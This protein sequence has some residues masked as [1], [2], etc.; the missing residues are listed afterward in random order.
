MRKLLVILALVLA[1]TSCNIDEVFEADGG[2]P[3]IELD[4]PT[5]VYKTKVGYA[6]TISPTYR[7]AD[8][9]TT[10]TWTCEGVRVATTPTYS[11]TPAS[12][13][14]QFLQIEVRNQ[15]GSAKREIRVDVVERDVAKISL[16]GADEGFV[17]AIGELLPLRPHVEEC[18]LP[19]SYSWSLDGEV[20]GTERDYDFVGTQAGQHHMVLCATTDDGAA[21]L[22]FD[23]TVCRAED[24][25]LEWCFEQTEFNMASGRTVLLRPLDIRGGEG[26]TYEWAVDGTLV[27]TG[28]DASYAFTSS[29][30]GQHELCITARRD[31]ASRTQR[32][33]VNVCAA[34]G[35]FFRAA[36]A[37]SSAAWTKIYEVCAA[38]GQYINEDFEATT[39]DEACRKADELMRRG[40]CVSLGSFGGYIVV[41]FDHSVVTTGGYDLAIQGNPFDTSSEPAIVYVMQ[42]ENGDGV[43]NDTWYELAGSETGKAETLRDYAVTYYRP[44]ASCMSVEWRDNRGNSGRVEYIASHHDQPS[45]YPQWNDRAS[46]TLR[47]TRLAARNYDMT[48]NG[49]QWMLP[50]YDWGYADNFSTIDG[51]TD[52][53]VNRFRITDA[54]DHNGESIT[55]A[56]IDFVKIQTACNANSGWLGEQSSEVCAI[57]DCALLD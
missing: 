21:S 27:Q 41:G 6:L 53:G 18:A 16:A 43:P 12:T 47:G 14:R 37:S 2:V 34:E 20:V 46:Y 24:M 44:T 49:A 9:T 29:D 38:P 55:L 31:N 22:E 8:E 42:D 57:Y 32:L 56:Y 1:A 51:A 4:S 39:A 10:Y 19:I 28:A 13:G 3:S 15:Y 23:I 26:A 36:T 48:G 54:I 11:F 35:E 40:S 7:N 30:I 17:A 45:Y 50:P 33:T 52:G 25:P 5:G